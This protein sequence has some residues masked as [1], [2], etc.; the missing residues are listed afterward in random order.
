MTRVCLLPVPV[1]TSVTVLPTRGRTARLLLL[2]QSRRRSRRR[3]D[4]ETPRLYNCAARLSRTT[5]LTHSAGTHSPTPE[6]RCHPAAYHFPASALA[7][8]CPALRPSATSL[9]T[10][11]TVHHQSAPPTCAL[12]TAATGCRRNL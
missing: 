3:N 10:A 9:S 1:R 5:N 4:V 11:E 7:H 8:L 2:V 6:R 12:T